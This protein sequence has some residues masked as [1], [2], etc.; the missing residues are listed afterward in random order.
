MRSK[1]RALALLAAVAALALASGSALAAEVVLTATVDLRA[2]DLGL[3]E[4]AAGVT[5]AAAGDVPVTVARPG[6]AAAVENDVRAQLF[7]GDDGLPLLALTVPVPAAARAVAA[8]VVAVDPAAPMPLRAPL[9]AP[10]VAPAGE[11]APAPRAA[12]PAAAAAAPAV[13]GAALGRARG[14]AAAHIVLR[15]AG[16][17]GGA[18]LR[19]ESIAVEITVET[20]GG[21]LAARRIEPDLEARFAR[22]R[23]RA[24][25]AAV[26]PAPLRVDGAFAPPLAPTA[27]GSPVEVVIITNEALRPE[28]ERLAHFR[29]SQGRRAQVRTV[30]WI[31][32]AYGGDGYSDLAARIRAFIAD[33]AGSW[34]TV[35]VLLGGDTD[36]IPARYAVSS[37]FVGTAEPIPC[38]LYYAALDGDWNADGDDEI[39]EAPGPAGEPGDLVDLVPDVL[40][41]RAPVSTREEARTF[42]D[43]QIVYEEGSGAASDYPASV[44]F[45]AEVLFESQDGAAIAEDTRALLTPAMSHA[46]LYEN[47]TAYPGAA[48]LSPASSLAELGR[49]YGLVEHVGHGFRN[50][51]SVG[52]GSLSNADVDGLENRPRLPVFLALNCTS[53]AIDFNSIGEHLVRNPAGGAIAYIGSSRYA[54]PGTAQHYQTAF[55]HAAFQD[56]LRT[57][58]E[59]VLRVRSLLAEQAEVEGAHRWTQFALTVIGD[60]LTP[61][62]TRPP[63]PL[64]LRHAPAVAP[65]TP[66]VAITVTAGGAAAAFVPVALRGADGSLA[67][68][69]TDRSGEVSL[70]LPAGSQG[71]FTIAASAPDAWPARS[72]LAIAGAGGSYLVA[73]AIGIDDGA[74]GD[75][76]RVAE[77]GETVDLRVTVLNAGGAAAAA[78]TARLT[79]LSGPATIIDGSSP[80]PALGPGA[81]TEVG[82]LRFTVATSAADQDLLAFEITLDAP[83]ERRTLRRVVPVA[84]PRLVLAG[85]T[86]DGDGAVAPGEI[87]RY[88]L[89]L[90][91]VGA[92]TAPAVEATAR[93]IDLATGE[94]ASAAAMLDGRARFGDLRGG[95]TTAGDPFQFSLAVDAEIDSLRLEVRVASAFGDEP[96]ARLDFRPPAAPTGAR[97]R[98]SESSVLVSWAAPPDSDLAGYLVE[99]APEA[100]GPFASVT[101]RPLAAAYFTD[102]DLAPLSTFSYRVAAV[103]SS[104]NR[105]PF[106]DAAAGTTSPALHPGWPVAMGQETASSPVLADLDGDG[107]EEIVTGADALYAWRGDAT[108]LRDGDSNVVTNGVFTTDGRSEQRGY[109]AVPAIADLD[110]DGALDLIA[111]A[112][113]SAQVFAWR[114]DGSR[115][116]GWPQSLRWPD[117][118]N[119][120]WGSPAVG[121]LDGDGDLEV[122]VLG[123]AVGAVYA[124]HH[125]GTEVRD[126][127]ANPETPGVLFLPD[128]AAPY[129][130]ATPALADLDGEPGLEVIVGLDESSGSLHALRAAGGEAPGFPVFLGGRISSSPALGDL[131]PASDGLEIAVAVEDDSLHVLRA[132][133]SAAPGWPVWAFIENAPARTSS[134]VLADLDGDGTLEVIFAENS[135][136]QIH[137]ARLL[138]FHADGTLRPGFTDLT[139]ATDPEAI[140]ARAT[141]STPVVGDVDGDPEPEILLGAEDGRIYGWN[142]DASAVSGFPIQTDGEVRGAAA[143]GDVDSDGLVEVVVAGWD[144]R[145][146]VWDLAGVAAPERLPWPFFHRDAHNS[147][148]V[149]LP[150]AP[151]AAPD[152]EPGAGAAA[153]ADNHGRP[154][155][156][157]PWP[158]PANP[159]AEIRFRLPAAGAVDLSLYGVGGRLVR[160]LV[161]T[162]LPAGEHRLT[163]DGR[164]AS[165]ALVPSGVYWLRL[166]APGGEAVERVTV[167][168]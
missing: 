130:F 82:S 85:R 123:G 67:T 100:G 140:A 155:L 144:R 149:E 22:A 54:F 141:Q 158:S 103:D 14:S 135:A 91:N 105:S 168:R 148:N 125:D 101:P 110:G 32:S 20:D 156:L 160:E 76:D 114:R 86:I 166:L 137:Q 96:I 23:G 133:G 106:S 119:R 108:E 84:G 150:F 36:V 42:V 16:Y 146:Y 35:W 73:D 63:A 151:L 154:Q 58:G 162:A 126:G 124:W 49:G 107:A 70:P 104:G 10:A 128:P 97:T 157:A 24:R 71:P 69:E 161:A 53:A 18:L 61:L 102:R 112:W 113:D 34:G 11:G 80:F 12:R 92:G 93:V 120:N 136:A 29:T 118:G 21:D 43:R 95:E 51:L 33:A 72:G 2:A 19:Q 59:A 79:L 44:L 60:P 138:V 47:H 142:P 39:G 129:S 27:D 134:P 26:A 50:T 111:V 75:G 17:D 122:A 13:L 41:G 48:P 88:A 5:L 40:L 165:G 127:D 31:A 83:P 28:F 163:W 131:D 4:V 7:S 143:L 25:A 37:Y 66:E 1:A 167:I 147:G 55:F 65:G 62:F 94:P 99:R 68:A 45:L 87:V 6:A 8:R 164:S 139:F 153:V 117:T 64:V 159:A 109:H 56:T 78:G 145:L 132:D 3:Q 38:E 116:P 98:G 46:R 115:L 81:A 9:L 89:L 15:V 30:E 152:R 57:V 90:A 52:A 77:P 121:D 74:G